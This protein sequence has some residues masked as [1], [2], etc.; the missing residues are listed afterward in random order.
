[1]KRA[2]LDK[3]VNHWMDFLMKSGMFAIV[4]GLL[5]AFLFVD[6]LVNWR[7]VKRMGYPGPWSLFMW[8]PYASE[9]FWLGIALWRWPNQRK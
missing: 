7:L 3:F 1:M 9:L 6:L 2:E 5:G 8:M 4:L